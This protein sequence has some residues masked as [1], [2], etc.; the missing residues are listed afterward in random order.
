MQQRVGENTS[1]LTWLLLPAWQEFQGLINAAADIQKNL[2]GP[3]ISDTGA[4]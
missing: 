3:P 1:E 4:Y 2:P